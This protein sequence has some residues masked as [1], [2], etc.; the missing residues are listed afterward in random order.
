MLD[1]LDGT[2]RELSSPKYRPPAAMADLVRAEQ[3]ECSVAG[4]STPADE[5]DLDHEIPWPLGHTCADDL[6]P[7]CRR[8]HLL[9]THAGWTFTRHGRRRTWTTTTGHTYTEHP[10]GAIT[11][12]PRT[13]DGPPPY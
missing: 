6:G 8:H 5:C 3:P 11:H 7:R 10:D 13:D 2:V 12:D 1:P 4:C 9:R